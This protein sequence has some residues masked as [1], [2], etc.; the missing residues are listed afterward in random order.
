M[1]MATFALADPNRF[2]SP[3]ALI[4]QAVLYTWT[5]SYFELA[6]N[7]GKILSGLSS[8]TR[9]NDYLVLK[10]K[11]L[12]VSTCNFPE[13]IRCKMDGN[14]DIELQNASFAVDGV[15]ILSNLDVTFPAQK[16]TILTGPVASGKSSVLS[17]ILGEMDLVEGAFHLGTQSFALCSQEP[18]IRNHLSIQENILFM[19][20]MD[21]NSYQRVVHACALDVDFNEFQNGDQ[22]LAAGLSG[23]QRARVALARAIYADTD[24]VLLDVKY[25]GG[26]SPSSEMLS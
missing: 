18:I 21:K 20:P 16:L 12:Q 26:I 23:G 25:L 22:G 8:L 3:A 19:L 1:L 10:E 17:A 24:I 4:L 2:R 15:R 11:T 6:I 7:F 5:A 14:T 9:I 13:E